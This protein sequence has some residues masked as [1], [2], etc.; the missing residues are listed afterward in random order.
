MMSTWSH[1]AKLLVLQTHHCVKQEKDLN[2]RYV[3]HVYWIRECV[4]YFYVY[5]Q[6]NFITLMQEKQNGSGNNGADFKG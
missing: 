1:A 4:H 6:R 5:N 2:F 3:D